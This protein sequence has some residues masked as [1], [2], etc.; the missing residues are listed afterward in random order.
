MEINEKKEMAKWLAVAITGI[1]IGSSFVTVLGTQYFSGLQAEKTNDRLTKIEES[2]V[3]TSTA[4]TDSDKSEDV[5]YIN[6]K[7]GFQLTLPAIWKEYKAFEGSSSF[8]N[9]EIPSFSITMPT[10]DEKWN[11]ADVDAGYASLFALTVMT[12]AQ[13]AEIK[14]QEGPIPAYLGKAGKYVV[15]AEYPNAGPEDPKFNSY[16]EDV[17]GILATFGEK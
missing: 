4:E 8:I 5:I 16:L 3:K 1:I 12:E 15:G 7:Y 13:W 17:K 2:L 14:S 11:E 9:T 6:E 10:T